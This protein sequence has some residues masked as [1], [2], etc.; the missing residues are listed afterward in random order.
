M[1]RFVPILLVLV[2]VACSRSAGDG[3]QRLPDLPEP[4]SSPY[5][6]VLNGELTLFGGHT[7]GFV[8]SPSAWYLKNG[9]W[10]EVPMKYPHDHAFWT[11]LPDGRIMLGGGSEGS[12]G[13]GQSWGVEVYDPATHSFSAIGIMN[14]KRAGASALAFPDGR[15]LISGNWYAPDAMEMYEPGKGFSFV[16]EVAAQRNIPFILASEE[17]NAII[18]SGLDNYGKPSDGTVDRLYGEAFHVPLLD[19][20]EA[21]GTRW[22]PLS[23]DKYSYLVLARHRESGEWR[24]LKI[25]GEQFSLLETEVPLPKGSKAGSYVWNQLVVDRSHRSAYT[26]GTDSEG[27][28]C[29]ACICYDPVFDGGKAKVTFREIAG[30][31]PMTDAFTLLPDGTVILPG[32]SNPAGGDI[33]GRDYFTAR[34]EVWAI[35]TQDAA[36]ASSGWLWAIVAGVLL[37]ITAFFLFRRKRADAVP[38]PYDAEVPPEPQLMERLAQIME[39]EQLYKQPDLR[40]ADIASRLATN[41]TYVSAFMKSLSGESF[42]RLVNGYRVRHAQRLMRERPDMTVTEIAEESGFS[43]RSSFYRNFKDIT[44]ITPAEWK[45]NPGEKSSGQHAFSV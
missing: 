37:L 41:R 27:N 16:K 29:I 33:P 45:K 6:T 30:P 15:V 8:L 34:C 13:I 17:N 43:S 18:F 31:F 23:I 39:E 12:F 28:V 19:E 40:V 38:E 21:W 20:W 42:S 3:V 36:R 26:V 9:T 25:A 7:D 10:R 5:V 1:K 4:I 35:H 24:I 44:G 32:G 2:S 22:G 14:H 11:E